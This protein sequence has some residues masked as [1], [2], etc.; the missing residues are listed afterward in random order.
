M[1]ARPQL[2]PQLVWATPRRAG[3]PPPRG[4]SAASYSHVTPGAP[5]PR[6][7][8]PSASQSRVSS[9]RPNGVSATQ[10]K[11]Q[12]EALKKQQESLAKAAELRSM[13][14]NL[15]KVD[16]EGRRESL[17]DTLCSADDILNLPQHP[18]PPGIKSGQLNVDLLKH[19]VRPL[20]VS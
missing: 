4:A 2:E 20:I 13:L 17:L 18:D 14:N 1:D 19:Q 7:S 5:V 16:D 6:S 9:Q 12:Q 10:A 15:E 3:F 8:I 11:A